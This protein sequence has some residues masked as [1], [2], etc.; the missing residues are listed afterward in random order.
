[1]GFFDPSMEGFLWI[2]AISFT[3][4]LLDI[5]FNTEVLSALALLTVSVYLAALCDV[6]LKWQVLIVLISWLISSL[7][8]FG[9]VRKLMIPLIQKLIPRGR[10]ETIHEA[11]DAMA[12]FRLIDDKP[13]VSWNGDLWPLKNDDTTEFNDHEKVRIEAVENGIFTIEKGG[14]K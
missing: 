5:F 2:F 7:L 6:S 3:V 13:F 8:F 12:E 9:I 1:M 4:I 14:N 10:D 11:V